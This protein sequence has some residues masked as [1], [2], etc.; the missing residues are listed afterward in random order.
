MWYCFSP[1]IPH[2]KKWQQFSPIT[3]YKKIATLN[4]ATNK[5]SFNWKPHT[6]YTRKLYCPLVSELRPTLFLRA[7]VV[8]ANCFCSRFMEPHKN[9]TAAAYPT[10]NGDCYSGCFWDRRKKFV[11]VDG[12]CLRDSSWHKMSMHVQINYVDM[13]TAVKMLGEQPTQSKPK[14]KL[15]TFFD[16]D[17]NNT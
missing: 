7:R 10:I 5:K 4:L 11:I 3:A 14:K 17:L 16:H 8:Q 9:N 6:T 15:F 1:Q 2:K 12:N 13:M